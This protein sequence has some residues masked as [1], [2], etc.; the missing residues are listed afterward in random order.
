MLASLPHRAF[1]QFELPIQRWARTPL[2]DGGLR[3][4]ERR[5]MLPALVELE[6]EEPFADV[7]AAWNDEG[8]LAAFDITGRRGALSCSEDEWWKHD[9]VRLCIDTRDARE[10][11]RATRYCHLFYFMPQ[12]G[13]RGGK[14]PLAGVHKMNRAKELHAPIDSA[15]LRVAAQVHR[16]GY[17]LEVFIPG[18]CLTG[19]NP[20]EHPR[21]GLFYKVRD[22]VRGDQHLAV[23]D[24]LGW[25]VD[26]S[27]W[28]TGV[29]M[30]DDAK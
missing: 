10:A 5:F 29:L 26:P 9:G 3:K 28:V 21:I 18:T 19:W 6:G 2:I 13:G 25:N 23:T 24:E 15:E 7:Y 27:T 17:S 20:A 22:T 30:N 1:L 16:T 11:R 4:W 14:L 8:F 12:G